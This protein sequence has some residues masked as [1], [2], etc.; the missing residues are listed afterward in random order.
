MSGTT[1]RVKC[2]FC[3]GKNFNTSSD[4]KPH[5]SVCGQCLNCGYEYFTNNDDLTLEEV[6][7]LLKDYGLKRINALKKRVHEVW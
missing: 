4:W 2:P 6:N 3:G 5:E 1:D 7:D